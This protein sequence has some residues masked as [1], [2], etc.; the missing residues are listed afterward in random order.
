MT[1]LSRSTVYV[2]LVSGQGGIQNSVLKIHFL[3]SRFSI[4]MSQLTDPFILTGLKGEVSNPGGKLDEF[5]QI[6]T[7]QVFSC[8]VKFRSTE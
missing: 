1:T 4:F 8:E 2:P 6:P 7:H 5:S 3:N